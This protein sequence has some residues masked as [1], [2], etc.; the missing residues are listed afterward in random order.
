MDAKAQDTTALPVENEK[1][2]A[3]MGPEIGQLHKNIHS[4]Q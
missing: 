2:V 4:K 1:H 3:C